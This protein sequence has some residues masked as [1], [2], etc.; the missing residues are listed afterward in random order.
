M[1]QIEKN[2]VIES[3]KKNIKILQETIEQQEFLLI[4]LLKEL[5]KINRYNDDLDDNSYSSVEELENK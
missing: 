3:L 4:E 1:E 5:D 2:K